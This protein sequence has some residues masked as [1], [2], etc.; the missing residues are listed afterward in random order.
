MAGS[1]VVSGLAAAAPVGLAKLTGSVAG[2]ASG[3]VAAAVVT[4]VIL[5]LLLRRRGGSLLRHRLAGPALLLAG[6][7]VVSVSWVYP[8]PVTSTPSRFP[9]CSGSPGRTGHD[10]PC[11]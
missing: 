9:V 2:A 4:S 5:A 6:A 7:A 8:A 1:V 10:S 3:G 11:T